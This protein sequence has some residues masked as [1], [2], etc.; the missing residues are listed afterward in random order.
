MV[1]QT[2]I[3]EITDKKRTLIEELIEWGNLLNEIDRTLIAENYYALSEFLE[4]SMETAVTTEF[5]EHESLYEL[6]EFKNEAIEFETRKA[7]G[8]YLPQEVIKARDAPIIE[9]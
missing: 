8:D 3:Q 9:W 6:S 4:I 1:S 7:R 2:R 5:I